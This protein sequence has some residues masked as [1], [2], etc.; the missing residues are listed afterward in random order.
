[1]FEF[2]CWQYW[3]S[4]EEEVLLYALWLYERLLGHVLCAWRWNTCPGMIFLQFGGFHF[5]NE[6]RTVVTTSVDVSCLDNMHLFVGRPWEFLFQRTRIGH[7]SQA[8]RALFPCCRPRSRLRCHPVG[9]HRLGEYSL[10]GICSNGKNPMLSQNKTGERK[11]MTTG[12]SSTLL[13][14]YGI[15]G[16]IPWNSGRCNR[17]IH[18]FPIMTQWLLN[19]GAA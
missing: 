18:R 3:C 1:M 17:T 5:Q 13:W 2:W 11:S 10:C 12:E 8:G 4:W 7:C 19:G 14:A 6:W 16:R 15:C 9:H